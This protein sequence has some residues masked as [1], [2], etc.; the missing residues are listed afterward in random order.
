MSDTVAVQVNGQTQ[1][2]PEKSTITDLIAM[3]AVRG[4]RY[5]VEVNGDII[6]RGDHDAF[7]LQGGEQIEIVQAIGGG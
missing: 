7:A 5:A 1:H 6:P 3:Q 2:L 4:Q